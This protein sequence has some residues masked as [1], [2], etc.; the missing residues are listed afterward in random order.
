MD[1]MQAVGSA[2]SVRR[3]GQVCAATRRLS[4]R[5]RLLESLLTRCGSHVSVFQPAAASCGCICAMRTAISSEEGR[6][7]QGCGA[8]GGG[9]SPAYL[10]VLSA[11]QPIFHKKR[12]HPFGGTTWNC[13]LSNE[14]TSPWAGPATKRCTAERLR[15]ERRGRDARRSE[16]P[17]SGRLLPRPIEADPLVG[18][19]RREG[20]EEREGEGEERETGRGGIDEKE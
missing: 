1:G 2:V 17:S 5:L 4:E 6:I 8:A 19:S 3:R 7:Q 10:S 15:G 13:A 12:C 18:L 20:G 16:T 14:C 11:E 9:S